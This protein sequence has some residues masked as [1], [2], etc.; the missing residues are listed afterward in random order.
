M[1]LQISSNMLTAT[2]GKTSSLFPLAAC[3]CLLF[4]ITATTF[5]FTVLIHFLVVITHDF[6][7]FKLWC[8]FSHS[9]LL[10]LSFVLLSKVMMAGIMR[11]KKHGCYLD[12]VFVSYLDASFHHSLYS[13]ILYTLISK[14][15][16][17]NIWFSIQLFW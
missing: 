5:P 8:P 17:I 10:S 4:W 6:I 2:F 3:N 14:A 16:L 11:W 1:L 13:E 9:H 12:A 7:E 15:N